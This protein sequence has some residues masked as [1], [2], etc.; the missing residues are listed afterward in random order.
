MCE[1]VFISI[2]SICCFSI[3]AEWQDCSEYATTTWLA[4]L[5]LAPQEKN[6]SAR[7]RMLDIV[8]A[9]R[10]RDSGKFLAAFNCTFMLAEPS[11]GDPGIWLYKFTEKK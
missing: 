9:Y 6:P 1:N 7:K 10:K 4:K 5:D 3:Q 11:T 8:E 2:S